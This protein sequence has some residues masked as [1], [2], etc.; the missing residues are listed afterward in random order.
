MTKGAVQQKGTIK[1]GKITPLYQKILGSQGKASPRKDH[2]QE[3]LPQWQSALK[4]D[5]REVQPGSIPS[6]LIG[7]LL[8]PV[9]SGLTGSFPQVIN[10]WFRL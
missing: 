9:L 4:W 6:C 2:Q 5:L 1:E 8:S 3:I 7:E 10:Q